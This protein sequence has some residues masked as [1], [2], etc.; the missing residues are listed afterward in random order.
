METVKIIA[1]A[2]ER[3][4]KMSPEEKKA[5]KEKLA[6]RLEEDEREEQEELRK[7]AQAKNEDP[8]L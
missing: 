4:K 8:M 5:W 2:W 6:K 3:L 1:L 7:H